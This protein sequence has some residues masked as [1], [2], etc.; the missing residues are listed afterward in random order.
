MNKNN[1]EESAE[2][3][4]KLQ[5]SLHKISIIEN[6][7]EVQLEPNQFES[8]KHITYFCPS[9]NCYHVKEDRIEEYKMILSNLNL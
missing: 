1:L 2:N 6:G 8:F 9:C 5:E 7:E 3:L 4:K